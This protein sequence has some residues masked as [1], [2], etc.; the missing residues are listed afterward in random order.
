MEHYQ[1]VSSA[2]S[3]SRDISTLIIVDRSVDFASV[4]LSPL[5]YEALLNEVFNNICGTIDLDERV[6][7]GDHVKLQMTSKDR[8]FMK[9]RAQHFTN[10]FSS[11]S[12]YAKQLKAQQTKAANMS[13]NEMKSFVQKDL[14]DLQNQSKAVALHIGAC[15]VIQQEKGPIY[16][17]TLPLEHGLLTGSVYKETIAYLEEAMAQRQPIFSV[18]RL[19]C[20]L[21]FCNNGISSSDYD[22]LKHQFLQTYGFDKLLAFQT[23]KKMGLLTSREALAALKAN[24]QGSKDNSMNFFKFS[25]V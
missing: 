16:E 12:S 20:L 18:L 8:M 4:L 24:V 25:K 21:S 11:L 3:S 6:T 10:I 19:M 22:R 9:I 15:E 1:Q 7:K 14:K 23:L 17:Y 2:N 5:T 13:I